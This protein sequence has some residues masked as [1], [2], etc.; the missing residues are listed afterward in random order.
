MRITILEGPENVFKKHDGRVIPS[1]R[2]AAALKDIKAML[3]FRKERRKVR[4]IGQRKTSIETHNICEG[5]AVVLLLA[6]DGHTEVGRYQFGFHRP[7][8][9]F[10]G[11][12]QT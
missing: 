1:R 2:C 9:G 11:R 8:D 4:P 10:V 3:P 12:K 7:S 5:F 6:D